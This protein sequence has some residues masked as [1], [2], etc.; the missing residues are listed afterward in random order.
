MRVSP[1]ER[2][3]CAWHARRSAGQIPS[4]YRAIVR[5]DRESPCNS[6]PRAGVYTLGVSRA[7]MVRARRA[8]S[9][10]EHEPFPAA[11]NP[12]CCLMQVAAMSQ[13]SQSFRSPSPATGPQVRFRMHSPTLWVHAHPE[14]AKVASAAREECNSVRSLK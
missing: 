10:P 2:V 14:M 3:W 7:A 5:A 12:V 9:P 8:R 1:R 4:R 6:A 13:S 11:V